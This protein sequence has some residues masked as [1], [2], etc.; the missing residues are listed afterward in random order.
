MT[1]K[2]WER[3]DAEGGFTLV[4]LLVVIVILGILAAV[5]V[6][7]VG[8]VTD[9]G[10]QS[11]CKADVTSVQTASDTYFAINGNYAAD[12]DELVGKKLLRSAPGTGNGYTITYTQATGAV[13]ST[14]ACSTL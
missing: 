10:K 7:A 1:G 2:V 4:E 9:K 14:P 11:A 8:G 12:I 6:F 5:A 13:S 3:R